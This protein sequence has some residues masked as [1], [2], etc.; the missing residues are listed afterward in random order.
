MYIKGLSAVSAGT[1]TLSISDRDLFEMDP[2]TGQPVVDEP[3]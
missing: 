2:A 1:L 3:R